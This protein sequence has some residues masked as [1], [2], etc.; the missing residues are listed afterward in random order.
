MINILA[1]N[2]QYFTYSDS[3]YE[4]LLIG[5]SGV[6]KT[7]LVV[8]HTEGKLLNHHNLTKNMSINAHFIQVNDLILKLLI[9]QAIQWDTAGQKR[10]YNGSQGIIVVFDKSN[11]EFIQSLDFWM[12]QIKIFSNKDVKVIILGNNSNL[13]I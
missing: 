10:Y 12:E 11:S 1:S 3:K 6:G 2:Y 7:S 13:E 5:N 9:V 8:Q 4:I